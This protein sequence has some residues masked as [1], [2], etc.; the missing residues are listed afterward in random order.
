MD[1]MNKSIQSMNLEKV[2]SELNY[3]KSGGSY[4]I[5]MPVAQSAGGEAQPEQ[6]TAGLQAPT[7]LK[8]PGAAKAKSKEEAEWVD[9]TERRNEQD[10]EDG[11]L[12]KPS[13]FFG[14]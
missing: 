1:T 12:L 13:D 7:G 11:S 9:P 3:L 4:T 10:D 6:I 14:M 2:I 8:A 5:A